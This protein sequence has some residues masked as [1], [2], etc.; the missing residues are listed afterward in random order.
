MQTDAPSQPGTAA[1]AASVLDRVFRQTTPGIQY[2]LW[3]GTEGSV[4]RPDGSFTIV[5]HDAA[6]FVEA[7]SSSGTGA[8]ARAFVD[9]RIDVEG[10]L[11][12]CLRIGNQLEDLSLGLWERFSIWRQLR[13][14]SA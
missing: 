14:V 12:A 4:G 7:F 10:D 2:R 8:L 9:G 13:R 6:T 11:F 1:A 3:E 5:V